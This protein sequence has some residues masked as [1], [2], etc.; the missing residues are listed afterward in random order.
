MTYVDP[1]GQGR[2]LQIRYPRFESGRRL[3]LK[4]PVNP[5]NHVVFG[6]FLW[7]SCEPLPPPELAGFGTFWRPSVRS[8]CAPC[9]CHSRL[10]G[11][12]QTRDREK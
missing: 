2:E 10:P 3:S 12:P 6:L 4:K 1:K 9:F 5:S 11:L 8:M 7:G